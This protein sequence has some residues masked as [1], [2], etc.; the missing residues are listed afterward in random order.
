M[1]LVTIGL[2]AGAV[3][4]AHERAEACS[5]PPCWAGYVTPATGTTVPASIPAL[6]WQPMDDNQGG[7]NDIQKVTLQTVAQ[8]PVDVPFTA[9]A[10]SGSDAF[11]IVPAAP[12]AEGTTYT[13]GDAN[14]CSSLPEYPAAPSSVFLVSASAPLPGTLGTVTVTDQE[15]AALTVPTS[16]GSCTSEVMAD[17]AQLSLELS[18]DAMPWRDALHVETLIDN[19]VW[20]SRTL[21]YRVCS[22]D[23]PGAATG[24]AAGTHQ[25]AMRAT[26]PG[27]DLVMTTPAVSFRLECP[28]EDDPQGGMGGANGGCST[29][30]GAAWLVLAALGFVR[31]RRR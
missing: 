10:V 25:L 14:T 8:P 23:D 4:V 9:M 28:G 11:L 19:Q 6:Y 5:P 12:L 17:R 16:S 27:T 1:R 31:R 30:S 3:L 7:G 22:S 18:A 20:D 13:L 2:A 29:T 26:L 21:A 24:L 15:V